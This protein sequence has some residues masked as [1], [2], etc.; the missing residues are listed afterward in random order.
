MGWRVEILTTKKWTIMIVALIL[1]LL[2]AAWFTS[3]IYGL[4]W[5]KNAIAE[6][7]KIHLEE[8][9]NEEFE[10]K[11]SF[12]NF[13]DGSYGGVFY[14][15]NDSTLEFYAEEGFAEYKYVDTYPEVLWARQLEEDI[16]PLYQKI[17]P[18]LQTVETHYVT[19]QSLDKVKGP[20]IPRY[21]EAKAELSAH[22][23]LEQSFSNSE[24]QWQPITEL[25]QMIQSLSAETDV[26]FRF[27]ELGKKTEVF[28]LC[29]T[30]S[31]KEIKTIQHA[32]E[33]CSVDRYDIETSMPVDKE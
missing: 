32:K 20:N 28:I 16:K 26:S 25:V 22:F 27:L 24:E 29:P 19:Y 23:E 18:E 21:D 14:P 12:Y 11:D 15:S 8:K 7:L 17:Y 10:R 33:A 13:K 4:P 30:K 6:K 2:A 3:S 9:Y 1:L 5:K 31:E